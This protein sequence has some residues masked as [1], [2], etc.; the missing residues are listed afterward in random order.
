MR[1][2]CQKPNRYSRSLQGRGFPPALCFPLTR[3]LLWWET[4]VVV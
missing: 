2:A 4:E 3:D 1:M